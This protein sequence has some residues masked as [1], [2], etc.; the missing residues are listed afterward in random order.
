MVKRLIFDIDN[1]LIRGMNFDVANEQTLKD[2]NMYTEQNF[3]LFKK[4]IQEYEKYHDNYN[5]EDYFNFLKQTMKCCL[6]PHF[7]DCFFDN[8][9]FLIPKDATSIEQYLQKMARHYELVL[10][11]NYFKESQIRRLEKMNLAKYFSECYGEEKIKP[12]PES[13]LLACQNHKPSECVMIGDN[14]T[15]D[16]LGAQKLGLNTVFVN[17][18]HI[19]NPLNSPEVKQVEEITSKFIRK[20]EKKN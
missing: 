7:I 10:L 3:R 12:Y 11:T 16:I 9:S 13:F 2:L 15:V 19:E 4:V 14:Y 1:T 6:P 17:P 8:L 5:K 20:L 18:N